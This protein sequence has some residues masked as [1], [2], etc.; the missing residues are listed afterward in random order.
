MCSSRRVRSSRPTR[1]L[2]PTVARGSPHCQCGTIRERATAAERWSVGR[3]PWNTARETCL[4]LCTP[5]AYDGSVRFVETSVFTR[6]IVALLSDEEYRQLQHALLYRPTQ[7]ALI[8]GGGG[9]RKVR[10][11]AEGTGKR[12]GVRIIY[13]WY[14]VDETF[15]MLYVYGKTEQEIL[16]PAQL[17]TL[18]ALIRKELK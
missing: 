16:T 1:A 11:A 17:R 8:R 5:L 7:G 14:S 12:G 10:W 9:L 3:L 15:Y 18:T 13:Y 2:Q 6:A 4:L